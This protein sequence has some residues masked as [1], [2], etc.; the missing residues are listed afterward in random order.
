MECAL[1]FLGFGLGFRVNGLG[2]GDIGFSAYGLRLKALSSLALGW[3]LG[4]GFEASTL[5]LAHLDWD[6]CLSLFPYLVEDGG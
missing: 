3:G 2:F 6:L 4:Y 1:S 5:P